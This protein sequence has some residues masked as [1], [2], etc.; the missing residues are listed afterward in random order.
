MV[1]KG[2][3]EKVGRKRGEKGK[4]RENFSPILILDLG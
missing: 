2:N 1:G 3:G 4:S